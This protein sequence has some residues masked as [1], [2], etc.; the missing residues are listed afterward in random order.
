MPC[1]SQ[2]VDDEQMFGPDF[3]VAPV[4]QRGVASR[5]VYLPPLPKGTV[6]ANVFTGVDT[7]TSAGGKN[8]SEATPLDTFPLYKRHE[9][10]VYPRS[11]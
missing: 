6:W 5:W 3:L 7:D 11:K 1:L 8:I 10:F 9:K 4:L 2:A